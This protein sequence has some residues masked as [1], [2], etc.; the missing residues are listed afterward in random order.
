MQIFDASGR[1]LA[2]GA[3]E[4]W[5]FSPPGGA[6]P[7]PFDAPPPRGRKH[8]ALQ[9]EKEDAPGAYSLLFVGNT[10]AF[11]SAFEKAG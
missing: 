4:P 5:T 9:V 7:H 3:P 6:A 2:N 10:Y 8:L 1:H 11:K